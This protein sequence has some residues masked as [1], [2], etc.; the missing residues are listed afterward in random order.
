MDSQEF[1]ARL[2]ESQKAGIPRGIGS[3]C[4]AHRTV[5]EAALLQA[6][7]DG[8]PVLI[9]STVNQVNQLGG[10]T[11]MTPEGFRDFL[12]AAA[13]QSGFP[14]ER[15]FIGGDHLG[16][17]PWRAEPAAD[18]MAKSCDLV[19][20]SVRAG[21]VKIHLDASMPL[22]GDEKDSDGG[23]DPRIIADREAELAAAAELAFQ[24]MA[25]SL[26][27]AS[28]PVYVI[29]TE[30][31]APGGIV[32]EASAVPVTRVDDFQKTV[33][34]C[35][36]SFKARGIEEAWSRVIAVVAQPGVE[37]GDQQI[38]LYDREDAAELCSAARRVPGLV[39]EGHSTDYQPP[40]LLRMLV[41]D[42]VAILKVGPALTFALR[43]CLF[44][45]ECIERE[46]LG[47]RRG[48][49]VS[50]LSDALD[51]AMLAN[52]THWRGYYKGPDAD[53]L[54]AR[55]FSFSDRSRYYWSEPQVRA[56]VSTLMDNLQRTGI[57]LTLLS[58]YLP[59]H[60]GGVRGGRIVAAPA[61]LLHESVC[62]VLRDYSRATGG[63]VMEGEAAG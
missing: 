5:I 57:P 31:P 60:F 61:A 26:A 15:I 63:E 34:L 17:Y 19:A 8:L 45:L 25:R 35:G 24:G 11:G 51:A 47:S 6:S 37:Y 50:G 48:A 10:Y 32:S 54:V 42:G 2:V 14:R 62:R 59:G 27:R 43:E 39:L 9:E 1:F 23:L 46:L 21:Y 36:E 30:V 40:D 41:E 49:R 22:G 20:A 55:R 16:P 56:S 58:Q 33:S 52:P 13:D 3:V 28:P 29:G 7:R 12:R 38:H 44:G 53:Q 4:S 18:A